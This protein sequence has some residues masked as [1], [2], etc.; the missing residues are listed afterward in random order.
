MIDGI[1]NGVKGTKSYWFSVK[2]QNLF[3]NNDLKFGMY[4]VKFTCQGA[5]NV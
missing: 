4:E 3:K 1:L 2:I 5:Q